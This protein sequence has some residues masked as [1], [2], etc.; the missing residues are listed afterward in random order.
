MNKKIAVLFLLLL[1]TLLVYK[2]WFVCDDAFIS[3][4]FSK[5]FADGNGLRFNLGNHIPIEGYSNFLWVMMASLFEFF[6]LN[7]SFFVPF[8]SYLFSCFLCFRVYRVLREIYGVS[9]IIS[10]LTLL[11]VV[12]FT[13]FSVWTTSGLATMPF[14][15]MIFYV[16]ELIVLRSNFKKALIPSIILVLLRVEGILWIIGVL[17]SLGFKGFFNKNSK[18]EML[19]RFK[20]LFAYSLVILGV[21]LIYLNCRYNYFNEWLPNTV[22][23]KS[24]MSSFTLERGFNYVAVYFLSFLTP[25]LLILGF[26]LRNKEKTFPLVVMSGGVLAYSVLVGGDF[27]T[28]GRFLLPILPYLFI[29]ISVFVSYYIKNKKSQ[30]IVLVLLIAL[31]IPSSFNY[32][33]VPESIRSKFHFRF[34]SSV[35]RGEYTQWEYMKNNSLKWAELGKALKSKTNKGETLVA[36]AIGNLGYYSD[37][38]IYDRFG[39]VTKIVKKNKRQIKRSPG[40]DVVVPITYFLDRKPDYLAASLIETNNKNKIKKNANSWKKY[41]KNGYTPISHDAG[42]QTLIILKNSSK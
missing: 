2:F 13:P 26:F 37:L 5:N 22:H 35:Y 18:E 14:A 15:T 40:H 20:D 32:H 16:F 3:F 41:E 31:Q 28:M 4:T 36:G 7:L 17:I 25:F 11:L 34:N 27:M 24:S 33:L 39:L 42:S 12:S 8:V 30:V 9:S 21:M 19:V 38:F 6:N 1:H 10:Y 29:I 23:A